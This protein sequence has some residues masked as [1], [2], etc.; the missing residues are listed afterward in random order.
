[1]VQKRS[2]NVFPT[3]VEMSGDY[4]CQALT[5]GCF[6]IAKRSG[7]QNDLFGQILP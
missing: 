5:F 3:Q 2:F 4:G 1:M 7:W 6:F